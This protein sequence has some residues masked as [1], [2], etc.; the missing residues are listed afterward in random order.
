M[1]EG[2]RETVAAVSRLAVVAAV[3]GA[4]WVFVE[5]S[6][7][8]EHAAERRAFDIRATELTARA[9]A[10]GSPLACLDADAGEAVQ[11]ACEK[12]LFAS[13]ESVA[14][15]VTY[16][17]ARLSFLADGLDYAHRVDGGFENT[18]AGLRHA[19]EA[20]RY[21][22]VAHVLAT[23]LGCAAEQCDSFLLLR[24][25]SVVKAN[26]AARTYQKNVERYAAGWSEQK[27][28]PAVTN[29]PVAALPAAPAMSAGT[30]PK[31][32]FPTSASIPPVSIMNEPPAPPLPA[33]AE[34][35][36]QPRRP[37]APPAPARKPAP[38]AATPS[39]PATTA[40]APRPQ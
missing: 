19:V 10:P 15:A 12:S 11:G 24:D 5:R 4:A 21:G 30:G 7:M 23:R 20:D 36:P 37:P 22:L 35:V 2:L 31:I 8:Q 29:P 13:P 27:I 18:L 39:P 6:A 32:D 16:T 25:A 9:M 34:A 38:A 1:S 17:S 3:A 14:A 26:M 40:A 33:A 28:A